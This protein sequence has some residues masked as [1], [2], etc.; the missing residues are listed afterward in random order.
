MDSEPEQSTSHPESEPNRLN[1]MEENSE[2]SS[3]WY[4]EGTF[5]WCLDDDAIMM[6]NLRNGGPRRL[7]ETV[8]HFLEYHWTTQPVHIS[9]REVALKFCIAH[10]HDWSCGPHIA[11]ICKYHNSPSLCLTGA[12]A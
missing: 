1:L 3:S 5:F 9:I 10:I 12:N 4:F 8:L 6:A 11:P 7:L 2:L